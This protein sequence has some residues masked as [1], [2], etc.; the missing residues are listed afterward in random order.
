MYP[1]K[2]PDSKGILSFLAAYL[3]PFRFQIIIVFIS[4]TIVSSAILGLGYALKHLIDQGFVGHN[5]DSLNNAFIL[6]I[7]M[8]LLLS[9]AGYSRSIRVNSI[10]EQLEANI[11]KD[12]YK[13]IIKISPTYYELNK[14]SDV[15]SR[16]TTDLTLLSNSIM[17]IASY[18]IRNSLMAIGGL[19]L[20]LITSAKLTLYVL[21]IL[22]VI[23]LPLIIIGRKS[24]KLSKENQ[25]DIATANAHLE[26]TLSFIKTVQA[27]NREDFEYQAFTKLVEN[28]QIKAQKRIKLRSLLFALVIG[29]ILSAVAFVL[30]VGGQDVLAGRMTPGSLSSFIFYSILVATSIGSL[31]EFYSDWQRAAG[32]L[33]RV[34][35]ILQAKSP[36]SDNGN[37]IVND[38]Q[39]LQIDNLSFFY[40]TR[41]E[42]MVLKNIS[43]RVKA[44]SIVALV[45]PSGAGK[46]TIFNLLLRFIDP[47][48]GAIK[49]GDL[50]IKDLSLNNLRS[51]FALVSQDPVI[52]SGTAYDNIIYGKIEATEN[53]V[54]E[55]AKA[56]EIF[57]FFQSLPDGLNTSLG[58]K[59]MKLS[60]GQKQRIAIARAIL[61]NPKILLLDEATSSL[62]NENEQLVQLALSR[63][64]KGRTTLVIAHRISTIA[65]A[66][67]IIVIDK[68]V[69]VAQGSHNELLKNNALYQRLSHNTSINEE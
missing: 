5:I 55:A 36:I 65:N 32:A 24:K 63:L 29:L 49:I 27:Y 39:D 66:D 9:F 17:L 59:G 3:I 8:V 21:I 35:E 31:S 20:L 62:D 19:I 46:S 52:F 68:G 2:Q 67:L 54:I 48:S 15:L 53:E 1:E 11:K 56:A 38:I 43:F 18:S 45:G 12:A 47:I 37:L 69:V 50:D 13:N 6:L 4:I 33:E 26:E 25:Q 42:V 14:L 60:G 58:E 7:A 10:C 61:R 16:L 30:W 51:Q 41:P 44:A 34:I 28:T 64:R 23:L 40:A 57:E 22:P